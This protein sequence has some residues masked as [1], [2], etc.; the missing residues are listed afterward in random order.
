[1]W[2]VGSSI[3]IDAV[4]SALATGTGLY[5]LRW[6]LLRILS[7]TRGKKKVLERLEKSIRDGNRDRLGKTGLYNADLFFSKN[8]WKLS[9]LG[10][11]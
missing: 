10:D 3:S 2:D 1:V 8:A 5:I 11:K 9:G 4:V 6:N 7:K